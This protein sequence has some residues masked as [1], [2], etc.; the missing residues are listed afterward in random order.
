MQT[1][2]IR[3]VDQV[4]IRC[5]LM[6]GGTSKGAFFL[7]Q[8]LPS[9]GSVRDRVL[10]R[11]MG[12]PDVMQIDGLGGTH[13]VTSKIAIISV[14]A[15]PDADVDY[16]FGQV[17][18]DRDVIDYTGNCGNLSAGV[19]PFAIDAGLVRAVEPV[20]IV[21]IYNTNTDKII[22]AH[23]PVKNGRAKVTGDYAIAGVPGTG[24]EIFMDYSSTIGAKTGKLLPTGN[25][26]D[27]I[28]L[29]DG[30]EIEATLCDVANPTAYVR[31]VDLALTGNELPDD[32]NN[33]PAVI[34]RLREIR[35]K[36][37]VLMGFTSD[38][39]RADDETPLLPFVIFV[40]K[41][42]HYVAMNAERIDAG[43]M[44]LRARMFFMNKLHESMAGTASMCSAAASRIPG[45]IVNEL[46]ADAV[47]AGTGTLRIGHPLGTMTVGVVSR[48]S[49]TLGGVAF[50]RLG[51]S[52][53]ARKLMEGV[54][55]IPETAFPASST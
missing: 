37:A 1:L 52:R 28:G 53:T 8:D 24:A 19:G 25:V 46:V 20:T 22:V 30:T 49:N 26:R 3:E 27:V 39:R 36:A 34:R 17:E 33:N 15:R 41:P 2:N 35:G 5:S 44:D 54:V 23:V 50:E 29:D 47:A 31:A 4:S 14:S 10:K 32:V 45:S 7:E 48:P 16:T 51:F 18:L 38:W 9:P 42:G 55:Y 21:R 43:A 13:L 40:A 12:T 6:R 11:I